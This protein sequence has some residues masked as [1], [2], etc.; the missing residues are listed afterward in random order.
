MQIRKM[1]RARMGLKCTRA[2]P[3]STAASSPR[4]N[5]IFENGSGDEL[6][7]RRVAAFAV[8]ATRLVPPASNATIIVYAGTWMAEHL[9][10]K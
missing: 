7:A 3:P 8:C 4:L 6:V 2:S 5:P 10:R 9:N 1:T